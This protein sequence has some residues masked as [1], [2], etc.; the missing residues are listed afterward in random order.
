MAA[1]IESRT[2]DGRLFLSADDVV[3]A[4]RMRAD[5]YTAAAVALGNPVPEAL[6]EAAVAYQA[7]ANELGQ[8]ADHIDLAAIAHVSA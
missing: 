7:I 3:K 8:R 4:L 6:I 2:I 1:Q 5:E